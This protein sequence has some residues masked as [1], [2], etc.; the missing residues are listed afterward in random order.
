MQKGG[1]DNETGET[2]MRW[3]RRQERETHHKAIISLLMLDLLFPFF[4][5]SSPMNLV[6]H[7]LGRDFLRQGNYNCRYQERKERIGEK[8]RTAKCTLGSDPLHLLLHFREERESEWNERSCTH[9]HMMRMM[10]IMSR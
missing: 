7:K 10:M 4:L 2:E 5:F 1:D 8:K 3:R 9:E 6:I